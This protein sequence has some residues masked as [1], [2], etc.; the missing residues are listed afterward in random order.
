MWRKAGVLE[1]YAYL[2]TGTD[3][4][5]G[6]SFVVPNFAFIPGK[7]YTLSQKIILNTA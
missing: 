1:M 5:Y 2:P 3:T 7:T 6:E 4:K